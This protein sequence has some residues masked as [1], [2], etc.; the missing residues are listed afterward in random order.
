MASSHRLHTS[1]VHL[2]FPPL[3]LCSRTPHSRT[4][5]ATLNTTT[6]SPAAPRLRPRHI[7]MAATPLDPT[8]TATTTTTPPRRRHLDTAS[9]LPQLDP[10]APAP[11]R[12][13]PYLDAGAAI[14]THPVH[15]DP[16]STGAISTRPHRHLDVCTINHYHPDPASTPPHRRRFDTAATATSTPQSPT[17]PTHPDP[18]STLPPTPSRRGRHQLYHATST[19]PPP[20]PRRHHLST[21]PG[22][23]VSVPVLLKINLLR[24][25]N[26]DSEPPQVIKGLSFP[27]APPF[28]LAPLPPPALPSLPPS[29]LLS[30]PVVMEDNG[31]IEGVKTFETSVFIPDVAAPSPSLTYYPHIFLPRAFEQPR[32]PDEIA[33]VTPVTRNHNTTYC[34]PRTIPQNI[35]RQDSPR[36]PNANEENRDHHEQLASM[37]VEAKSPR[38]YTSVALQQR[39]KDWR[40]QIASEQ[41]SRPTHPVSTRASHTPVTNSHF[42]FAPDLRQ[43]AYNYDYPDRRVED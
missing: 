42:T 24:P 13:D 10:A 14:A 39:V 43:Y 23:V 25:L 3:N 38:N 12:H 33:P 4:F 2:P 40:A 6:P 1:R 15:P 7:D 41:T 11:S 9:P 21:D 32:D 20:P 36:P 17:Y 18:T 31:L 27:D 16:T 28:V 30:L 8:E 22:A 35:R 19:R 29:A 34:T 5:A 37:E 26:T